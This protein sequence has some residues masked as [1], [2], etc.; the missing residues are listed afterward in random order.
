MS[1]VHG[2]ADSTG[3]LKRS[4]EPRRVT[5][6]GFEQHELGYRDG[7]G[8]STTVPGLNGVVYAGNG[9]EGDVGG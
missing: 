2:F 5:G 3:R 7:L 6:R 9:V 1:F 8:L 4:Q